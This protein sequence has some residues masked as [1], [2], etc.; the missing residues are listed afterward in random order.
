MANTRTFLSSVRSG[1]LDKVKRL[2]LGLI[3]KG[4][5]NPRSHSGIG[6]KKELRRLNEL[7]HISY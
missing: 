5:A 3:E 6:K 2:S 1:N 4:N 7:L